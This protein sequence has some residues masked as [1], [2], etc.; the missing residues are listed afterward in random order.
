MCLLMGDTER[1]CMWCHQTLV[2]VIQ[3]R[4]NRWSPCTGRGK[5]NKKTAGRVK[6]KLTKSETF[7]ELKPS[8][9]KLYNVKSLDDVSFAGRTSE[10]LLGK[11]GGSQTERHLHL[12][13]M[14][15][16]ILL[17]LFRFLFLILFCC[18]GTKS[19]SHNGD[20]HIYHISFIYCFCSLGFTIT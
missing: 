9:D 16:L 2:L 20:V 12:I 14:E 11:R 7:K 8:V 1:K 17:S 19:A 15:G 4:S 6:V 3:R 18:D 13:S 5:A 10:E